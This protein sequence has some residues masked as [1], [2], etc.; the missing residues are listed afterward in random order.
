MPVDALWKA[1]GFTRFSIWHVAIG[2]KVDRILR[3]QIIFDLYEPLSDYSDMFHCGLSL[4]FYLPLK[5]SGQCMHH[6]F[7]HLNSVFIHV[8]YSLFVWFLMPIP[9]AATPKA[10]VWCRSPFKTAVSNP[11]G[12]LR[13]VCFECCVLSGRG[14]CDGRITTRGVIA[15]NSNL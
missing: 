13:C 10:W 8:V 5:P 15:C 12:A 3:K 1:F 6:V 7:E 11:A 2:Q 14:V 4:P 9:M